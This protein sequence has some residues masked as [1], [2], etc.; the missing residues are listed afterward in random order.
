M[1]GDGA[2]WDGTILVNEGNQHLEKYNCYGRLKF[3]DCFLV[4]RASM[5]NNRQAS[6]RRDNDHY[7]I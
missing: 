3:W 4:A 6:E 2:G 7:I 5:A 1:A